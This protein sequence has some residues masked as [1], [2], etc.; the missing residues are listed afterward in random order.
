MWWHCPGNL[1]PADWP[2]R[3]T[4]ATDIYNLFSEWNNGA[5]FLCQNKNTW[6]V[7]INVTDLSI[8]E[9]NKVVNIVESVSSK[10]IKNIIDIHKCSTVDRL[11]LATAFILRFISNLK[12][13]VQRKETKKS[14]LQ[15]IHG[16][17]QFRRNSSK[18]NQ[19]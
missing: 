16:S 13:N 6:P 5:T 2:S 8:S 12:F 3:G 9:D 10:D 14:K 1:N 4:T 19:I 11:F 18:I 7:D 15:N 17:N